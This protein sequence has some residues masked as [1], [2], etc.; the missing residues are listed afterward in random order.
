MTHST[1]GPVTPLRQRMIEDMR[2]SGLSARTQQV[3]IDGVRGLA[4]RYKRSPDL[5]M[6]EEVRSYLLDPC[7]RG[8]ARG[9]FK[10]THYGIR[11]PAGAAALRLPLQQHR[12]RQTRFKIVPALHTANGVIHKY[13]KNNKRAFEPSAV[14]PAS[15]PRRKFLSCDSAARK[16][17]CFKR[18]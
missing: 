7:D 17:R 8:A 9:T 6:E 4:A 2:L 16:T 1:Q 5:L 13:L 14:P 11:R 15:L 3:Y 12:D 10:T 18:V